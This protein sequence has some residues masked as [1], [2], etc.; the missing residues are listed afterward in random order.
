MRTR[1]WRLALVIAAVALAATT[2]WADNDPPTRVARLNFMK[3]Q[4]ALRPAGLDDWTDA[5]LNDPLTT[6]DHLWTETESWAELHAGSTAIRLAPRT[7]FAFLNL[8]DSYMQLRLSEGSLDVRVRSLEDSGIEVDT[9]SAAITLVKPGVYRVDVLP[10]SGS[11]RVTVR[12]GQAEVSADGPV[13][14]VR[15]GE[16]AA[17]DAESGGAYQ[18]FRGGTPDAW[19]RWCRSRDDREDASASL[20]YVSY[21]MTGYEDLD[22]NGTWHSEPD[23][24]WV[25]QPTRVSVGWAPYRY[26]HWRWVEPWGWTWIDDAAWGFA[27]FHYGRWA[28]LRGSWMWVPGGYVRRPVYAPA[29]VA[30]IGGDRWGLS[31]GFGARSALVWFP[32]G[33]NELWVPHYRASRGYI[34]NL[35]VANVHAGVLNAPSY[36]TARALYVNRGVAGAVTAVPRDTFVGGHAI[37]RAA[38]RVPPADAARGDIVGTGA[39]VAPRAE[40]LLARRTSG[41]ARPS[42]TTLDRSVVARVAPPPSPVPFQARARYLDA[43]NGRPLDES[44]LSSIRRTERTA[45]ETTG[46]RMAGSRVNN[47][48]RPSLGAS[49]PVAT[50]PA[51]RP[52]LD[53]PAGGGIAVRRPV[54]RSEPLTTSGS[55]E[56]AATTSSQSTESSGASGSDRPGGSTDRGTVVTNPR[57]YGGVVAGSRTPAAPE[58]P[59]ANERPNHAVPDR[60]STGAT[61]AARPRSYQ[62]GGSSSTPSTT[63]RPTNATPAVEPGRARLSDRPA[64]S[65]PT[66]N[67]RPSGAGIVIRTPESDNNRQRFGGDRPTSETP[68]AVISTPESRPAP[69]SGTERPRGGD[70]PSTSTASPAASAPPPPPAAHAAP[71]AAAP[72]TSGSAPA[73]SQA[74]KTSGSTPASSEAPKSSGSAPAGAR[75]KGHGGQ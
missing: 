21:E 29:L 42:S 73:S 57:F 8:D 63:D 51:A 1:S 33:P 17:I 3:G 72:K 26:G 46:V 52:E 69:S 55:S 14:R 27:P 6:G 12:Y 22:D 43:N 61:D 67:D 70:R 40:S 44:T 11:T 53:T 68:R 50:E 23:Y 64:S 15:E 38:F 20:R 18:V 24:G 45:S 25:W 35:N 19:E 56:N 4:V 28:C 37:A 41:T 32:L 59:A 2:V 54:D 66:V 36:T 31:L 39:P 7:A 65:S 60:S 9:P 58:R 34:H 48:A 13:F 71:A 47:A 49:A 5:T 10:D 16:A 74:P 62:L 30:F 75:P